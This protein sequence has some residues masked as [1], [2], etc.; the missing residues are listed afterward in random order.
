MYADDTVLIY[1]CRDINELQQQIQQDLVTLNEWMYHNSL[2]FNANKTQFMVFNPPPNLQE[3]MNPVIINN[4]QIQH[5]NTAKYL[6]LIIDNKLIWKPHIEYIKSKLMPYLFILRRTKYTL[7]LTTKISLYY[8]YF[9]SNLSYLIPIWGYSAQ[10]N[11]NILQ[12]TQNKAIRSLFWQDYMNPNTNTEAIYKKY[13]ILKV[14][15]MVEYDSMI[16]IY[17]IKHN[18][19]RNNIQLTTFAETHQHNTRGRE[20]FRLP[21]TNSI[22]LYKSLLVKGLSIYNRLPNIIKALDQLHIFK[23][24]LKKHINESDDH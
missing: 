7:P 16:M 17:K 21:R 24:H 14:S 5:T 9:N 20:N 4:T 13:S 15:Q 3:I 10:T 12:R 18:L 1:S 6:G 8:S 23:L 19:I 11:I 2:S 22:S